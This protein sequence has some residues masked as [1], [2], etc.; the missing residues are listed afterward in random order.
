M[1]LSIPDIFNFAYIVAIL[2]VTLWSTMVNH[3]ERKFKVIYYGASTLIGIYGLLV[4]ALLIYN[5]YSI[6][7]QT[8]ESPLGNND[9]F[10]I[11]L[12]YLRALILFVIA[13]FALP[14]L[15]TF[16]FRKSVEMLTSL[17]SYIYFSPTYVNILQIFSFC[18]VDDLSWG[19]K[20]LDA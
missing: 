19:T 9:Q 18:R 4:L 20:G 17:L 10:L 5:T 12:I 16:S 13:G 14:I 8:T 15:W 11:P 1:L 3:N 2:S 7:Q 6:I